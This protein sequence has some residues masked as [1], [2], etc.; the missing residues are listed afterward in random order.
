MNKTHADRK[1]WRECRITMKNII[2]V[3]LAAFSIFCFYLLFSL[4][5]DI[6]GNAGFL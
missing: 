6:E 3:L 5:K 4:V 2:I 1:K